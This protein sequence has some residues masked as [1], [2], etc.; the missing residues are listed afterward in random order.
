MISYAKLY[1]LL[2]PIIK[3]D[4]KMLF[5][6]LEKKYPKI[7]EKISYWSFNARR[8]KLVG[9][10]KGYGAK[11]LKKTL[12]KTKRKYVRK[13]TVATDNEIVEAIEKI[14]PSTRRKKE[15]IRIGKI[16]MDNPN[17][18]HSHLKKTGEVKMCD[19]NFYQFRRKFC[20]A[21]GLSLTAPSVNSGGNRASRLTVGLPV[22]KRKAT[23]YTVLYERESNGCDTK[24]KDLVTEIFE[25]LQR[26]KIANL[27]MVELVHPNKVLEI[28]SYA[29]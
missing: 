24:T 10:K 6:E 5:S 25:A 2:D 7:A 18:V 22:P 9:K 14:V 16:L 20:V 8:N 15:Y 17:T 27:E 29:K 21:M 23:L 11:K 28:R 3:K 1:T 19:A 13:V 4:P 12:K 26:E